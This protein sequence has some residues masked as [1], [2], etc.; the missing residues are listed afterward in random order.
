MD[1]RDGD[2][3][4]AG[5]CLQEAGATEGE[6]PADQACRVEEAPATVVTRWCD[7]GFPIVASDLVCVAFLL[8][9]WPSC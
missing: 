1:S 6:N 3:E 5:A 4:A 9:S 8:N 2:Q 7:G